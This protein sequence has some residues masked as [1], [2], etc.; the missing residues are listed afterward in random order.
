MRCF[1][2]A[3]RQL[4]RPPPTHIRPHLRRR[5]TTPQIQVPPVDIRV[6]KEY[7]ALKKKY[8]T[9]QAGNF[10]A[11]AHIMSGLEKKYRTSRAGNFDT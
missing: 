3:R 1:P 2:V 10:D 5:K 7:Q 4:Q 6:Y 11:S 9:S 8:R